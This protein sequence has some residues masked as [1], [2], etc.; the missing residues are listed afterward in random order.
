MN[1]VIDMAQISLSSP[2][3]TCPEVWL[4]PRVLRGR[5]DFLGELPRLSSR[6]NCELSSGV[7]GVSEGDGDEPSLPATSGG[8]S[9]L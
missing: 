4:L 5:A 1:V 7:R 6:G 3:T 9:G 8:I 2:P